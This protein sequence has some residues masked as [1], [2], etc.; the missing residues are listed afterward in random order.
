MRLF[1]LFILIPLFSLGQKSFQEDICKLAEQEGKH[2]H[3]QKKS[4]TIDNYDIKYHH[5][6]WEIDPQVNYIKGKITIYFLPD[7]GGINK[8]QFD[9]SNALTVDSVVVFNGQKFQLLYNHLPNNILEVYLLGTI[10]NLDSVRVYYQGTPQ[11][12]GLGSF[13]QDSH[14]GD[15]IIWT[16]SE[17]FGAQDWWPCK[18]H[19]SDKADSIDIVVKTTLGNR[20]ASNGILQNIDTSGANVTYHWKHR[21]PIPAYLV[22]IAI[23]NY[24]AFSHFANLS[25]GNLE[26]LNY[27]YPEDSAQFFTESQGIVPIL[28][29]FDTLIE[30]YPFHKEKYGHAQFERGGGMEHTTMSFMGDFRHSLMAHELAHQWF[31]N[32]V[33]CGSWRDIWLNEGFATYFE[34]LT[35]EYMPQFHDTDWYNWKRNAVD[36]I[37]SAIWGGIYNRDTTNVW[38]IFEGRITYTKG[39]MVLHM[40]RWEIGDS[41]FFAG[42]RNYLN[43]PNLTFGYA[44][45]EDLRA[46]FEAASGKNLQEFFKDWV[47]GEGHPIMQLVW[48]V[49]N[50]TTYVVLNQTP[51]SPSVS[52]FEMNVPIQF[53]GQGKDTIITLNHTYTGQA[54]SFKLGFNPDT[55]VFDPDVWLVAELDTLYLGITEK[56]IQQ[57]QEIKIYPNPA[58]D[59]LSI[60]LT[61]PFDELQSIS[62]TNVLGQSVYAENLSANTFKAEINLSNLQKGVYLIEVVTLRNGKKFRKVVLE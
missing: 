7:S 61:N 12:G 15:S 31:G 42:V 16:L 28:E 49:Q 27:V 17:P 46:H 5:C 51:S 11:T 56:N 47:Y 22:A 9:L 57:N 26:I 25:T 54:Y 3:K 48:S 36:Y 4:I 1:I 35:V 14:N 20:V 40:I 21:Y 50:D 10:T 33:T 23:T 62:I 13:M 39:A 30:P 18:Q 29:L 52:F 34:G 45:T 59:K 55:V 37:T 53:K 58:T 32:K 44:V 6:Y 60:E 8:M 38:S 41:A 24:V 19:L 43:D 2:Y